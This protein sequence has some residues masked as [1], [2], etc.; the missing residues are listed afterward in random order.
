MAF[1]LRRDELIKWKQEVS[2]GKIAFLTHYWIDSRFPDC[3]TVT[4]VGCSDIDKLVE[5]GNKYGL[6][7]R[8][9]HR[10]EHFPHYDL[11]GQ[12]QK[13]ILTAEK[14]WNQLE[15]FID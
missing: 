5:W 12:I 3:D 15:R 10:D 6:D 4:K 13:K 11:M 1:G 9:I 7:P 8:W 14:Q 2:Q